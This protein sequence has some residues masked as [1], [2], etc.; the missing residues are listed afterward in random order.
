MQ[1]KEIMQDGLSAQGIKL[2]V[3]GD[4]IYRFSQFQCE[5][6]VP[7]HIIDRMLNHDV[8][9]TVDYITCKLFYVVRRIEE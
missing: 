7:Q 6:M 3:V 8:D 2:E 9:K 4:A 5:W 1:A